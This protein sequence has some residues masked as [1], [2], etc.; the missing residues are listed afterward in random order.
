MLVYYMRRSQDDLIEYQKEMEIGFLDCFKMTQENIVGEL[1]FQGG[2]I[3]VCPDKKEE[4]CY[5][6]LFRC[7]SPCQHLMA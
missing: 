7:N 5:C 1:N 6:S 4:T 3:R 2:V